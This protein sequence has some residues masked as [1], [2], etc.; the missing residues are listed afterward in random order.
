L[1]LV[2]KLERRQDLGVS[3]F[4]TCVGAQLVAQ[5]LDDLAQESETVFW[6]LDRSGKGKLRC[7]FGIF[8]Y[9]DRR[10][11]TL[12]VQQVSH[13]ERVKVRL[14]CQSEGR[15]FLSMVDGCLEQFGCLCCLNEEFAAEV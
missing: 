8:I 1:H 7:I 3:A 5:A 13:F 9:E 14:F 4:T 2:E 15:I 12:L 6:P 11:E 10:S